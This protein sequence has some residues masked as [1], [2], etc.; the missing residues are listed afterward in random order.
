MKNCLK[1]SHYMIILTL[2]LGSEIITNSLHA[3]VVSEVGSAAEQ[4]VAGQVT[5]RVAGEG[6]EQAIARTVP[7]PG[8]P[9]RAQKHLEVT[10]PEIQ[11]TPPLNEPDVISRNIPEALEETEAVDATIKPET[12]SLTP[13]K[14]L[15]SAQDKLEAAKTADEVD[16]ALTSVEEAREAMY[17]TEREAQEDT[18]VQKNDLDA[19]QDNAQMAKNEKARLTRQKE[20]LESDLSD[21][22]HRRNELLRASSGEE[23]AKIEAVFDKHMRSQESQLSST[24]DALKTQERTLKAAQ[25]NI[26]R[27]E[28]KSNPSWLNRQ[29]TATKTAIGAGAGTAVVGTA[30]GIGVG[31]SK[32]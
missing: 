18:V 4:E 30:V 1:K 31:E 25:Q 12:K 26:A 3:T 29:S 22:R 19:A 5:Q 27:L 24:E 20:N 11:T 28:K 32:E 21:M 7:A 14:K 8:A 6:A 2:F 10:D 16:T 13:R 17:N 23:Y 9:L 15:K